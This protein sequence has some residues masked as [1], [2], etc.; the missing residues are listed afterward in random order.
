M[1]IGS[2]GVLDYKY[3]HPGSAVVGLYSLESEY[4]QILCVPHESV[5][6]GYMGTVREVM[7]FIKG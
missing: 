6:A 2:I 5:Q 1:I 7:R 4:S 3:G